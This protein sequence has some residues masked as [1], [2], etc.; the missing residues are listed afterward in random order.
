MLY[1]GMQKQLMYTSVVEYC[2]LMTFDGIL[3]YPLFAE[4]NVSGFC[5]QEVMMGFSC[6]WAKSTEARNS[7][8]IVCFMFV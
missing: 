5:I 7:V 8:R 6:A 1:P 4:R 3:L 2:T